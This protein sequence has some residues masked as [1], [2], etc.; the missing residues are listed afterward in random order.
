MPYFAVIARSASDVAISVPSPCPSEG[1]KRLKNL[2]GGEEGGNNHAEFI[3]SYARFFAE[4]ILRRFIDEGLRMTKRL[5]MTQDEGLAMTVEILKGTFFDRLRMSGWNNV[6]PFGKGSPSLSPLEK[7]EA[8]RRS[9]VI[10]RS[11]SDV[12]ISVPSPCHSEGGK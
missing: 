10:A 6:S 3:L 11:V 2:G 1:G 5:R 4:F 9:Y 12:A 7:G 8:Q